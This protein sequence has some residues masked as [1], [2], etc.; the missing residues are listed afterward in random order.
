MASPLYDRAEKTETLADERPAP[1]KK[2]SW[3]FHLIVDCSG[4]NR[5]A[6]NPTDVR[7]F[8]RALIRELDMKELTPLVMRRVS[9]EE[10]RG[11]SA[12]QMI[13]TSSITYHE[14]DDKMAVY[15]D[16]FSCKTFKPETALALIR[17]TFEPKRLAHKF[18]FR[19]AGKHG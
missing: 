4:C 19:D 14:D 6:D 1:A 7:A 16:V 13:T 18:L 17:S 12:M 11:I 3:G 2:R 8:F 5:K 10:G 9:G 15:L